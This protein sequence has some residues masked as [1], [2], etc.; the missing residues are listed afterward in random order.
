MYLFPKRFPVGNSV[1]IKGSETSHG[2]NVPMEDLSAGAAV[3]RTWLVSL[4]A[5]KRSSCVNM[6]S[7]TPCH[8]E[9]SVF[10]DV[11]VTTGEGN[12]I[13]RLEAPPVFACNEI[14]LDDQSLHHRY[15]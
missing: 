1:F 6:R 3:K 8:Y 2:N 13:L 4:Q 14:F 10:S 12:L 5:L 15:M 11:T 9:L 7:Q